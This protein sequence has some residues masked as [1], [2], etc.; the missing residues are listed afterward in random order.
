[1]RPAQP[2]LGVALIVGSVFLMS[3]GDALIKYNSASFTAWQ[4]FALR[5]VITV[6]IL[7]ALMLILAPGE[8][9]MPRSMRWVGL[10]S[11]LLV[12]MWIAYYAALPLISLSAAAVAFYTA[13]LFMALLSRSLIGEPVGPLRWLG[14][15]LGFVGVLIVLRPGGDTFSAAALLPVLAALFYALAAIITRAQCAGE[16]PLVLAL[17]LN[18]GLLV[19]GLIASAG[20]ALFPPSD[21]GV[22]AHPFLFGPWAAMGARE[23]ALM[24]LLAVLM[25]FFGTGVAMAYQV[26]PA[27]LIG[28][29]DYSYV[30]FAVVWSYV[31]FAERP[32]AAAIVGLVLIAAAGALVAGRSATHTSP[33]AKPTTAAEF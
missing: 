1:M 30:V 14:I 20:L 10:R 23:W 9:L 24:A 26:A 6:P 22:A 3:F 18:L 13:P 8:S 15:V 16:R 11:T 2:L 27:A 33:P 29:F 21:A 4:I 31:L 25:V 12:L 32:D 7:I 5:S 28:T 17:G 19:A